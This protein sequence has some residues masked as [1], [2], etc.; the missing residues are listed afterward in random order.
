MGEDEKRAL[1]LPFTP[2]RETPILRDLAVDAK[3]SV[4]ALI[5]ARKG[6]RHYL[7]PAHDEQSAFFERIVQFGKADPCSALLKYM[8]RFLQ[9]RM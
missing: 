2:R 6:R 1:Q 7:C 3:S 4:Y 5:A 8:N 9:N